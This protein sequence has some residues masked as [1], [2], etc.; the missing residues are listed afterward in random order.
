[1]YR[2]TQIGL[3]IRLDP[4]K[5]K[6]SLEEVLEKTKGVDGWSFSAAAKELGTSRSTVYRWAEKLELVQ[7]QTTA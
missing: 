1:M 4:T 6:A 2:D 5:A 3:L 7:P